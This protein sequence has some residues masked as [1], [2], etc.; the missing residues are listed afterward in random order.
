LQAIPHVSFELF[1]GRI[2]G[3]AL[4]NAIQTTSLFASRLA[5]IKRCRRIIGYTRDTY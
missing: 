3:Y 2:N 1:H 5:S 4:L